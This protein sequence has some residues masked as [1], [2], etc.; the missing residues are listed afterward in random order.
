VVYLLVGVLE[1]VYKHGVRMGEN[2]DD[3]RG[4]A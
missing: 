3:M 1:L 2:L 4:A